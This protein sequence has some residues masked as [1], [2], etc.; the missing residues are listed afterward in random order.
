[1]KTAMTPMSFARIRPFVW[2]KAK[3]TLMQQASHCC[4][5]LKKKSWVTGRD[6]NLWTV[7]PLP[8]EG[9][10]FWDDGFC[11][12][13]FGSAQ[14]DR[15]VGGTGKSESFRTRET[16]QKGVWCYVHWFLIDAV[17]IVFGMMLLVLD[18]E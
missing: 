17:P 1:M 13:D 16:N 11:D 9:G 7:P 18:L 4:Q 5:V 8:E 3:T 12:F 2:L 15:V 14:N 6:F 10:Y